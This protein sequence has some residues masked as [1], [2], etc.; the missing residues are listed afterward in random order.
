MEKIDQV[1]AE[2][3]ALIIVTSSLYSITRCLRNTIYPQGISVQ[4]R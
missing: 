3:K 1:L 4:S 2:T